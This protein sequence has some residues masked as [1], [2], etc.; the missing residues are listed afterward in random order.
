MSSRPDIHIQ[1]SFLTLHCDILP[2]DIISSLFPASHITTCDICLVFSLIIAYSTLS[3]FHLELWFFTC[4]YIEDCH[5]LSSRSSDGQWFRDL[6]LRDCLVSEDSCYIRMW[7]GFDHLGM[8][9][10]RKSFI[11]DQSMRKKKKSKIACYSLYHSP[12]STCMDV[13]VSFIELMC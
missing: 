5:I 13:L 4:H 10:H 12:L 1:V 7:R 6:N 3:L 2:F 9:F 11:I 8:Y